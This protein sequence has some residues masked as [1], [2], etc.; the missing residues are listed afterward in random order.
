MSSRR[1]WRG[2]STEDPPGSQSPG[3][4]GW[5]S[6]SHADFSSTSHREKIPE[7]APE[8]EEAP[9]THVWATTSAH[10]IPTGLRSARQ[11]GQEGEAGSGGARLARKAPHA[12][13]LHPHHRKSAEDQRAHSC[14][15]TLES[16][17][18]S[19]LRPWRS[20]FQEKAQACRTEGQGPQI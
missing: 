20:D 16:Q 17:Q 4:P 10:G 14:L 7:A 18:S 13:D 11:Q 5:G 1:S 9:S 6:L 2:N 15:E 12:S 19:Q 8:R 3:V